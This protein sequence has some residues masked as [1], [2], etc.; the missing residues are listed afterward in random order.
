[1][2]EM[3]VAVAKNPPKTP[4]SASKSIIEVEV[5][6]DGQVNEILHSMAETL[7]NSFGHTHT[8]ALTL[9]H[10]HRSLSLPAVTA[11]RRPLWV[12]PCPS[13]RLAPLTV[14]LCPTAPPLPELPATMARA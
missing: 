7:Q 9:I 5:G 14:P 6:D 4:M 12:Q 2:P 13:L 8:H 1:V 11:Y 3:P 10:I